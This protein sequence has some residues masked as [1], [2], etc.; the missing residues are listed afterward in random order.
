VS[1]G[2]LSLWLLVYAWNASG[3]SLAREESWPVRAGKIGVL[4][5]V[6]T[7]GLALAS[8]LVPR[9]GGV[10]VQEG[11]VVAAVLLGAGISMSAVAFPLVL[12]RRRRGSAAP[13]RWPRDLWRGGGAGL[14][15]QLAA[16]A[17]LGPVY[18]FPVTTQR[19]ALFALF[20]VLALPA[21]AA[22]CAATSWPPRGQIIRA[23]PVE[24]ALAAITALAAAHWFVH[25]SALPIVLFACTLLF[26]GAYRGG[27]RTVSGAAAFGAV[28]YARAAADVCAF[29]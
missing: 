17:I 24:A 21:F 12:Q 3:A 14:A 29:Y 2:L 16:E 22:L 28:M 27:R 6:W 25:M 13:R 11:N 18:A 1:A 26:L 15:V 19:L 8:W 20:L 5:G 23:V 10:P 9:I 4:A 7:A